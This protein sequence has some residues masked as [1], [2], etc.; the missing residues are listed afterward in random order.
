M[1]Q[2]ANVER[3]RV[4]R[5]IIGRHMRREDERAAQCDP[6]TEAREGGPSGW[7][8]R[9]EATS[10]AQPARREDERAAQGNKATT[11]HATTSRRD[12]R[13]RRRRNMIGRQEDE[14]AA[15]QDWATDATRHATT[16]WHDERTGGRSNRIGRQMRSDKHIGRQRLH[17]TTTGATRG[18]ESGAMTT[19]RC[20]RRR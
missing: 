20:R 15:Q 11:R 19:R 9:G 17:A 4:R 18:R 13:T 14:R 7:G 2:P 12:K 10:N 5:N 8:D 6:A 1:Q 16:S 3:T